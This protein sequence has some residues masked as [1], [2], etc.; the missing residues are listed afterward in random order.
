MSATEKQPE[1]GQPA[2]GA[3]SAQDGPPS[4]F[5]LPLPPRV[6]LQKRE[7]GPWLGVSES[8]IEEWMRRRV[9]PVIKVGKL[10]LFNVVAVEQALAR[11]TA[12]A[13]GE[14]V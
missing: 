12:K 9:I 13:I 14:K 2:A 5:S 3:V 10:R 6:L 4:S 8:T 11:F 7:I 1:A